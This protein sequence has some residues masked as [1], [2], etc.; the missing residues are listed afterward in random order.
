[1][2]RRREVE[3]QLR[4]LTEISEI[5]GS[6]KNL[7]I[8]ETR[9]LARVRQAQQ[10]VVRTYE[11]AAAD[12]LFHYPE[13]TQWPA[14]QLR[15][16]VVIGSERGFCGD[17]NEKLLEH[18]GQAGAPPAPA[19]VRWLAVG[20]K[21]CLTLEQETRVAALL[22]G[23]G[24]AEEVPDALTRLVST[25]NSVRAQAGPTELRV[26]H[27]I[28]EHGEVAETPVLPPFQEAVSPVRSGLAPLLNLAPA[29]FYGELVDQYL[30]AVLHAMFYTSLMAEH[31]RRVQHL[32][33]ATRRLDEQAAAL[34]LR[35][36]Q[37][38]QEEITEEI[39]VIMLSSELLAPR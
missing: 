7:S 22:D 14:A 2:S 19:E 4:S 9:K 35:R 26:L 28:D 29:L 30:F 36:N 31:Q 20:R 5:M 23:P 32:D 1:M 6:M 12:F 25:I 3:E 33:G 10:Q 27:H 16:Y 24:V 17:F 8:M 11:R 39:E 21:L 38:R 15:L 34:G 37:L 13:L 18:L